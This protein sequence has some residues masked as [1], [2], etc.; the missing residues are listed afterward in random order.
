MYHYHHHISVMELGHLL[1]RSGLMYPEVCS[2]VYHDFFCQLGSSVSLPWVIYLEAFYLHVCVCVYIYI[3]I[4]IYIY[5]CGWFA[6][7]SIVKLKFGWSLLSSTPLTPL[8]SLKYIPQHVCVIAYVLSLIA[9]LFFQDL[10]SFSLESISGEYE[11]MTSEC[12]TP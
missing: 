1:T 9:W 2:K 6:V 3:Y 4:Y 11:Q 12:S 7:S 10:L 8:R 5:L